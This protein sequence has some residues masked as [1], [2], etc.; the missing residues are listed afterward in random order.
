MASPASQTGCRPRAG[1]SPGE[2]TTLNT[3]ASLGRLS[4]GSKADRR[5][6]C[7]RQTVDGPA[8]RFTAEAGLF[9]P[10]RLPDHPHLLPFII[11]ITIN[12]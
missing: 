7:A 12:P 6:L 5:S 4:C 10:G 3:I 9:F 1:L 2:I 11:D 8:A